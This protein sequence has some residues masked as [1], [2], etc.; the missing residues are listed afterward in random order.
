MSHRRLSIAFFP[1]GGKSWIAGVI[2]LHNL[3]RALRLLPD[4]ERPRTVLLSRWQNRASDHAELGP[5]C[6]EFCHYAFHRSFR[7]REKA[8]GARRSIALGR[9]PR[10][11]ESTPERAKA[12]L[13]FPSQKSLGTRFP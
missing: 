13:V 4:D 11:L 12:D 5:D 7:L 3:I 8:G 10:S 9:W 2:Y 1:Q 6:P